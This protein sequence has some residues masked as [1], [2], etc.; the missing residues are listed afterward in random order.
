L[1]R[2]QFSL[3]C[4][5]S[6]S[7]LVPLAVGCPNPVRLH[8]SAERNKA[9]KVNLRSALDAVTKGKLKKQRTKGDKDWR[10]LHI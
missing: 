10:T 1:I 5:K 8:T 2:L 9:K 3:L 6:G 7:R 4:G